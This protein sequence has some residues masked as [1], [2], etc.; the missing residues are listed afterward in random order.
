MGLREETD[1]WSVPI[2][3]L[4]GTSLGLSYSTFIAGAILVSIVLTSAGEQGNANLPKIAAMGTVF[5]VSGWLVQFVT[6]FGVCRLLNLPLRQLTVGLLGIESLPRNWSAS[7]TLMVTL[8]TTASLLVLGSIYRL[9][10][11]GFQMPV[12]SRDSPS[13]W[14][15][16]SIGFASVDSIWRSAA[17]LCW[18]QAICQMYPLPRALGRYMFAALC[19]LSCRRLLPS[20]EAVVFRRSLT[21]IALLTAAVALY[22]LRYQ[23][24]GS[25]PVTR[26][27]DL[28]S[29]RPFAPNEVFVASNSG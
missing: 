14:A 5:W 4:F 23:N 7:R 1:R 11:G 29:W 10:E 13:M 18:V 2:G 6:Y 20:T 28:A 9:V 22:L 24:E 15:P 17:W 26:N 12:L 27:P 21:A 19:S 16:P 8:A 3:Q 25:S